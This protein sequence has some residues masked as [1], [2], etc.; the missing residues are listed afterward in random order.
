[1]LPSL[2]IILVNR[3]SGAELLVC[4]TSIAHAD[5]TAFRLCRVCVVDDAS[6]D[7]S[8]TNCQGLSL[9]LEIIRN[10]EHTG[11]GASCNRGAEKS[12][13]DYILFLNTD[14]L[15][16]SDSL[17]QPILYME[18]PE[19]AGTGIVG[20]QLLNAAGATSRSCARFPTF[21]RMLSNS[22]GLDR[23][24]P[25]LFPSHQMKQWDHLETRQVDQ[26][27]GAFMLI[28]RALFERLG[29]YDER[30]FVYME[31]L[32][33]SLRMSRLGY[34]SMYLASAKAEHKGGETA[35]KVQAESLFFVL[36][37]RIQYAF[38]HFGVLRGC[39]VAA[40]VLGMEPLSRLVLAAHR[41]SRAEFRSLARAYVGLWSELLSG[42]LGSTLR[43]GSRP[44]SRRKL[45][46]RSI[47]L[48]KPKSYVEAENGGLIG[49]A[50]EAN[51]HSERGKG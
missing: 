48:R 4:L 40:C 3:N 35:R 51:F 7:G 16:L 43:R 9:P 2:D 17:D 21:G 26:V 25:S 37:S 12:S 44:G 32:D 41:R 10:L 1:M 19:Q 39:L 42:R 22:L 34:R 29:G 15:V 46:Q 20:I 45:S 18:R 31:D 49:A 14:C 33:L 23:I 13:A 6:T 24:F 27:I 5:K 47:V 11:Y 8:A 38:S 30:F 50:A 28:R 36:R